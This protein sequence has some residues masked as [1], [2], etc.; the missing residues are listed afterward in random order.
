[1]TT[2]NVG[3]EGEI[4]EK[5]KAIQSTL[6]EKLAACG[7]FEDDEQSQNR[8]V[9]W[10]QGVINVDVD[11]GLAV[12]C[13][14][15]LFQLLSILAELQAKKKDVV[16]YYP[17]VMNQLVQHQCFMSNNL[18]LL[19]LIHTFSSIVIPA[20]YLRENFYLIIFL[21]QMIVMSIIRYSSL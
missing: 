6:E 14:L 20:F 13:M 18:F 15:F 8:W 11:F 1:M 19:K 7:K 21:P 10:E 5:Q 12:L 2:F 3:S 4:L 16:K 17:T 9:I